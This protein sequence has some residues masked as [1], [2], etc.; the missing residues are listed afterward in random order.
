MRSARNA[1]DWSLDSLVCAEVVPGHAGVVAEA[2]VGGVGE[3]EGVGVPGP[4]RSEHVFGPTNHSSPGLLEPHPG[5]RGV[6]LPVVAE[7]GHA[8]PRLPGH[9]EH[10][11]LDL[12]ERRP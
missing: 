12:D 9:L 2:V 6:Q 7:P 4:I 1:S 11:G 8:R 3:D 5:A 10:A